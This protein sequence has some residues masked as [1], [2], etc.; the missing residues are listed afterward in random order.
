LGEVVFVA[1]A[2]S[3]EVLSPLGEVILLLFAEVVPFGVIS[4]T[5]HY[6]FILSTIFSPSHFVHLFSFTSNILLSPS[7]FLH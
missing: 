1:L 5:T 6:L 2:A 3:G 4:F 7:Q